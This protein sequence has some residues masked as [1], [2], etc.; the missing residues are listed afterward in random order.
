MMD[1]IYLLVA[2][3]QTDVPVPASAA[4]QVW[5]QLL[6]A[7]GTSAIIAAIIAWRINTTKIATEAKLAAQ[8]LHAETEERMREFVLQLNNGKMTDIKVLI[9]KMDE[10]MEQQSRQMERQTTHIEKLLDIMQKH[11]QWDGT[12]RRQR[13]N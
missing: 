4:G 1:F 8:R 13:E 10:R 5:T 11:V 2:A 3:L 7:T 6:S 9:A 12:D